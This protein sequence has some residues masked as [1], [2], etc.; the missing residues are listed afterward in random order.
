MSVTKLNAPEWHLR[1][2]DTQIDLQLT[3]DWI[4]CQTGIRSAADVHHIVD[5]IDGITL[6]INPS[7][8]GQ[9]DSALI[10][11]LKT[12]HETISKRSS[13]RSAYSRLGSS[14]ARPAIARLGLRKSERAYERRGAAAFGGACWRE[15]LS[16]RLRGCGGRRAG[17][18]RHCEAV[19]Q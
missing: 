10:A 2:E 16:S 7:G 11:F 14:R 8:L 9:W 4:A 15:V 5:D 19:L 12:L 3:G 6:R 17:W 18:E 13:H 1:R